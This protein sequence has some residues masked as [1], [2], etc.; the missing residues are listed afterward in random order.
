MVCRHLAKFEGHS[1]CIN[2]DIMF[3]ICQA[4]NQDYIIKGSVDYNKRT[5]LR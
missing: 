4:I 3:L 1:Y 5:L 2:R